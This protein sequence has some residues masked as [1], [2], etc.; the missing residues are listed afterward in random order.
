VRSATGV[1]PGFLGP[2]GL[3][4]RVLADQ[5]VQGMSQAVTGA[6][7]ADAHYIGVDQARDFPAVEFADLRLASAG[8]LCP[9]CPEG[10]LEI[11][12]GIEVGQ[13]FYL[14]TKYSE[15]MGA[16]YLDS[17]GREQPLEMG[18]YGIGISRLMAAAVEQNHDNNGIIWP[19][20]I[21][22]LQLVLLPINYKDQVLREVCETVYA[23]LERRGLDVLLDD[24]D[25]RP[26][27]K[28]KDADLIG[29]PL[30]VT[31]GAKGLERGMVELRWRRDGRSEDLP[32][33]QAPE[34]I[35]KIVAAALGA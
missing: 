34:R 19:F 27:V 18:C 32:L 26:G 29:I 8:D 12:R 20:A 5:A 2:L 17:D 35:E 21:A 7:E 14:G 16:R 1:A 13:V 25:E 11:H 15:A 4:L 10:A 22:P 3:K 30:R 33:A 6:N 31:V 24:R 28:F 9:R 23:D